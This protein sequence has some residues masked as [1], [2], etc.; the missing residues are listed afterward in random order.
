M[1]LPIFAP[2]MA[3]GEYLWEF[4]VACMETVERCE[5]AGRPAENLRRFA[6]E[7][8]SAEADIAA[9]RLGLYFD[10]RWSYDQDT[11]R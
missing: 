10:G 4:A 2:T 1:S 7:L 5:E 6:N 9:C 3:F 11:Y 8:L